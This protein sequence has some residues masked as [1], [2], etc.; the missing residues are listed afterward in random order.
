MLK[1]CKIPKHYEEDCIELSKLRASPELIVFAKHFKWTE[2]TI[3][4]IFCIDMILLKEEGV[5]VHSRY[6]CVVSLV[7]TVKFHWLTL[8]QGLSIIFVLDA[9][10]AV[11]SKK[12]SLVKPKQKFSCYPTE[13]FVD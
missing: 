4:A 2:H 13:E 1:L 6:F 8:K 7:A 3:M 5:C 9:K 11:I 10:A 12:G